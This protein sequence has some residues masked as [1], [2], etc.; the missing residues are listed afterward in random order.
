MPIAG[1]AFFPGGY[2]LWHPEGGHPLP[3]MPIEGVMVLG[4]DFHSEEGYKASFAL[5]HEPLTQPTWRSLLRLLEQV[6]VPPQHC[7]FT[8]A[9]M[10]LRAGSATTGPFPGRND[11][12]FVERCQRFL[13]EQLATQQ[14]SVVLTLGV[15]T[16]R[17]LAPLSADLADW[18]AGTSLKALDRLGPVRHGVRF[19][20]T[21][22]RPSVVA[23][24]HP[25]LRHASVKHREYRGLRGADAE[26]AMIREALG[27]RG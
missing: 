10:G 21:D 14:P 26:L 17:L 23:L 1:T 4:H 16:P 6:D 20:G 11:P 27:A 25:C 7:F 24:T 2:G 9:Y 22:A 12:G 19:A 3:P 8:N 18:R 15:Y 5:G 13:V